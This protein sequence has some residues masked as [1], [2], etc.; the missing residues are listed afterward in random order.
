MYPLG[1][2]LLRFLN[3][4]L[5]VASGDFSQ[6]LRPSIGPAMSLET[7]GRQWLLSSGPVPGYATETDSIPSLPRQA[8]GSTIQYYNIRL[9]HRSQTATTS[10]MKQMK[11]KYNS[12]IT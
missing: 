5:A 3:M 10:N 12:R 4:P 7:A 2:P 11:T 6:R 9:L 1:T 8:I